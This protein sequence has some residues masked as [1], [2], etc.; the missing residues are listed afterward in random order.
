M[1]EGK[2]DFIVTWVDGTDL[3]WRTLRSENE[4]PEMKAADNVYDANSEG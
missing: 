3:D 1:E 4:Q 2:I